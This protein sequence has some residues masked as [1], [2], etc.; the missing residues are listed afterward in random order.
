MQYLNLK[1]DDMRATNF[2]DASE[3]DAGTWLKVMLHCLSTE[4][5]GILR[6]CRAWTAK[7]WL[8]V[9]G[10]EHLPVND[11]PLWRWEGDDL[12]LWAF[13]HEK[14][15][16]VQAGREGGQ[17]GGRPRKNN[18][19]Q[20]PPTNPPENPKGRIKEREDKG[21][22]GESECAR[23]AVAEEIT[24]KPEWHPFWMR[25][26]SYNRGNAEMLVIP[27]RFVEHWWTLR[28]SSEWVSAGNRRIADSFE[29]RWADL[30]LMARRFK[31]DGTLADFARPVSA[32]EKKEGGGVFSDIQIE[33]SGDWRLFAVAKL[34][35]DWK[36]RWNDLLDR[37]RAEILAALRSSDEATLVAFGFSTGKEGA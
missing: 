9:C 20:N 12:H 8:R 25:A 5:G 31:A 21:M 2:V 3:A 29:A 37:L 36:G 26:E 22:E 30:L 33:P 13:P 14:Q 15:K 11:G 24:D 28:E 32:P 6:A 16:Q 34:E 4:N 17:K 27:P 18:P 23:V 19:P 10:I 7:T 35:I 1:T